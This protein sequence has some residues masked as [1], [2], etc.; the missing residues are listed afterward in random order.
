MSQKE[1]LKAFLE[2]AGLGK[3]FDN[4]IAEDISDLTSLFDLEADDLK[5]LGFSIG[6]RKK[7]Q[8]A[9]ASQAQKN[10]EPV[11]TPSN[12]LA[13][14][15]KKLPKVIA[16][17]LKEYASE[18]NPGMKLWFACDAIE[19]LIRL[20]VITEITD[21][22]AKGGIADS[23]LKQL[24][25][26]IEMPTL[27]AWMAMA[28]V[29]TEGSE[30][31]SPLFP[32]FGE[33]VNGPLTSLLYGPQNPGTPDTSFLALRNRLAHGGGLSRREAKR[34]LEIW[35][36][37][38]ESCLNHLSWMHEV[39]FEQNSHESPP[40]GLIA[41]RNKQV[42]N[43]WPL[44]LFGT[45]I[46]DSTTDQIPVADAITQIY[47]RKDVV[48]LQYTPIG[49]EGFSQTELGE[50]AVDAFKKLL[51]LDKTNSVDSQA[52]SI[53]GFSKEILRDASQMVGRH[54]EQALIEN[55]IAEQSEG[56]IWVSGPAGIGK[57][58][59]MAR[60][61]RDY[62]ESSTNAKTHVLPYRF[63]AGDNSRCNR[64]AFATYL[65]ER[66]SN[67]DALIDN[68]T[69]DNK[70]PAIDRLSSCLTILKPGQRLVIMID[71]L[72]EIHLKDP[73]F[74]QDVLTELRYPGI[75]WVCA[76]RPEKALEDLFS[77]LDATR[78][79]PKGL[80]PL[81][82]SD[83][84]GMILEK[85]GPLK[86]RLIKNDIE[87]EDEVINPFIELVAKR[88]EGLPLYVKYVIG[89]VLANRYRVL[90]GHET[91][92]ES[93]HNYHEQLLDG[94]AIG[95]LK[96]ILT[97]LAATL[98]VAF[99]PLA[100][101][102]IQ[103]IL[104]HR[105]I[106]PNNDAGRKLVEDGL[107]AIAPMLRTA[108]DP[109]GEDGFT[110]FHLS[111][112]GHILQADSMSNSVEM[113]R[114]AFVELVHAPD[115]YPSLANYL[116]RSGIDH[117]IDAK[118]FR[119]AA[120][121][122]LSFKWLENLFTLGKSPTDINGY[123]SQ[124]PMTNRK[125]DAYYL[126]RL[127]RFPLMVTDTPFGSGN[128]WL[129]FLRNEIFH[130]DRQDQRDAHNQS[131]ALKSRLV[132]D[133]LRDNESSSIDQSEVENQLSTE[134]FDEEEFGELLELF[135]VPSNTSTDETFEEYCQR[136]RTQ[137]ADGDWNEIDD[138]AINV[139][140]YSRLAE[141]LL[142]AGLTQSAVELSMRL[143]RMYLVESGPT[144]IDTTL[145]M[146]RL[147]AS[148]AM[149]DDQ[150]VDVEIGKNHLFFDEEKGVRNLAVSGTMSSLNRGI[151]N[152]AS[153]FRCCLKLAFGKLTIHDPAITHLVTNPAI[154]LPGV[155]PINIQYGKKFF[156]DVSDLLEEMI[157]IRASSLGETHPENLAM[158][159]TLAERLIFEMKLEV[160]KPILDD[161]VK[162]LMSQ[163]GD[164]HQNTV[165]ALSAKGQLDLELGHLEEA[166]SVFGRLVGTINQKFSNPGMINTWKSQLAIIETAAGNYSSAKTL[167]EQCLEL[168]DDPDCSQFYSLSADRTASI[169]RR[170][171]E[172]IEHKTHLE[173]PEKSTL[174]V[175]QILL[176]RNLYEVSLLNASDRRNPHSQLDEML[177]FS[178]VLKRPRDFSEDF[179]FL[180]G[181]LTPRQ[182]RII[183]MRYGYGMNTT[184]SLNEIAP[185]FDESADTIKE[186]LEQGLE[187][188]KLPDVS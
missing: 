98:A 104:T 89:D 155:D 68:H 64:E 14:L 134:K 94:L 143:C 35:Q 151:A 109:E 182:E 95:D 75:I 135:E 147:A 7:L 156:T 84:R 3:Y 171:L 5:E 99:E 40:G 58:Y 67:A 152:A 53:Q 37:P 86:K 47:V 13:A 160:A 29:L 100:L 33:F 82:T 38:F 187:N 177:K 123:W 129:N 125:I 162:L 161:V 6:H 126:I 105:N 28:K 113:A 41:K 180:L 83:I 141:L 139:A 61:M 181:G 178:R 18:D 17:P 70:G 34:L 140:F 65:I 91:L 138:T 120:R 179:N 168:F 51:G 49:A 172:Q 32:E 103:T 69:P 106:V 118:E 44:L 150:P 146:A 158:K 115:Q 9:V 88:A 59:L 50:E 79:F 48:R 170:I 20:I 166:R 21:L 183:R 23:Q 25:G 71:G 39:T 159:L 78:P 74:A 63:K 107:S 1:D 144:E 46:T 131:W 188:L 8:A 167:C 119:K 108:P 176:S 173:H 80:P 45:P 145:S 184:H 72:D 157:K 85:I 24:S 43:L 121:A 153:I 22:N 54:D 60:L 96:F 137:L 55:A 36:E 52:Y 186:W 185:Q 66:L 27:G 15:L 148:Y 76:G 165:R 127:K 174:D 57:S 132:S 26:K 90:D 111:L 77:S 4:L 62:A 142:F 163:F 87:H 31:S 149:F 169:I 133:A 102:E 19:L 110:L 130:E 112:R 73:K 30:R 11:I 93:L 10:T 122:L 114:V 124:L 97:P 136:Q 92:P 117:L 16:I 128:E 101:H 12:D 42:I 116:Y 164:T 56:V 175:I 81:R 2:S 154:N